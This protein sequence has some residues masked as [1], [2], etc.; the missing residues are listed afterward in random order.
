M[1]DQPRL[2]ENATCRAFVSTDKLHVILAVETPQ[3]IPIHI[4]LRA[5]DASSLAGQLDGMARTQRQ[6]DPNTQRKPRGPQ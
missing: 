3:S 1:N 4:R 6:V 2:I 5:V